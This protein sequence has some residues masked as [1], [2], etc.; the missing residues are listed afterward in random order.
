MG[1]IWAIKEDVLESYIDR[2]NGFT[3]DS[4][5]LNNFQ[6]A[7]DKHA[8]GIFMQKDDTK[9]SATINVHGVLTPFFD[10]FTWLFG[11]TSYESLLLAIDKAENDDSVDSVIFD[12]DTPGGHV[13]GLESVELALNS[14]TKKKIG[15]IRGSACSAGYWLASTMDELY[16]LETSE[17]GSIGAVVEVADYS[18]ADEKNGIKRYKIVSKCS[19]KKRPD[20]STKEGM[21][22]IQSKVDEV[23]EIFMSHVATNRGVT[24]ETVRETYGQGDTMFSSEALSRGMIDGIKGL[25]GIRAEISE[26]RENE[27]MELKDLTLEQLKAERGDLVDSLLAEGKGLGAS[28]E[29]ERLSALEKLKGSSEKANAIVAEA[30]ESGKSASDI[31]IDVLFAEREDFAKIK[32]AK[33]DAVMTD[34]GAMPVVNTIDA[35]GDEMDAVAAELEAFRNKKGE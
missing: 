3:M 18:K 12:F 19:P 6:L 28:A 5:A 4:T 33:L 35:S 7:E 29:R 16:G 24:L 2:F 31:T 25:D 34:A 32:S 26:L 14:M 10:F 20:L 30:I 21:E 8:S 17:V 22:V 11:G 13:S 27:G 1:Q 23:G 15:Y 9:R